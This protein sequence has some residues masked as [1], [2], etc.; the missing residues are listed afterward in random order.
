[1]NL[2]YLLVS[3]KGDFGGGCSGCIYPAKLLGF[4]DGGDNGP[5]RGTL[6]TSLEAKAQLDARETVYQKQVRNPGNLEKQFKSS[7]TSL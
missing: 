5:F 4:T 6:L 3:T 1:M 7:W 2:W